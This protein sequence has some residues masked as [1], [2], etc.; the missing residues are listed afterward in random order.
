MTQ[1][2]HIMILQDPELRSALRY[3]LDQCYLGDW[4]LL[5]QLSRNTNLYFYR[6]FIKQ[7]REEGFDVNII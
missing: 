2:N 1:L 3:V 4:F 6:A 7:L 5:L